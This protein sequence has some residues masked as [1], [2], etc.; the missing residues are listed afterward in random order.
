[1]TSDILVKIYHYAPHGAFNGTTLQ[2][3]LKAQLDA[4]G[5]TKAKLVDIKSNIVRG[6]IVYTVLHTT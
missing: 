1:M 5:I 6:S 2:T 3:D 4:D